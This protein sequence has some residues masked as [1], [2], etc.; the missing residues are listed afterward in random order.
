MCV[1]AKTEKDEDKE[2]EERKEKE[3]GKKGGMGK[4][5]RR[6]RWREVTNQHRAKYYSREVR[7]EKNILAF[8]VFPLSRSSP[9]VHTC[10]ALNIPD[11]I[12]LQNISVLD[13]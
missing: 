2:K 6:E 10:S 11:S 1:R 12:T 7:A 3:Q 5:G 8:T 4:E 9:K 13:I